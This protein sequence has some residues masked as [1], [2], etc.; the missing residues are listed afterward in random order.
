MKIVFL[1]WVHIHLFGISDSFSNM[2][3]FSLNFFKDCFPISLTTLN[4]DASVQDISYF[5]AEAV[6]RY[7]YFNYKVMDAATATDASMEPTYRRSERGVD[8][9]S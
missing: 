1:P 6:F 9:Y 3:S 2:I 4:F 5:T 7:N 8:I